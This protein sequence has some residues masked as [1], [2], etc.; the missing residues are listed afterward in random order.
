[1]K[2]LY[3]SLFIIALHFTMFFVISC[4]SKATEEPVEETKEEVNSTT[5]ELTAAQYATAGIELGK[6]EEKQI[7]G[8]IRASGLLDVPP[9]QLI[10]I[11]VPLGGTLK[12]T[13]LLQGVHVRKGQ[14]IATIENIDFVQMQQD[15]LE[16]KNQFEFSK[17]DYERQQELNK[18]NVNA[19]KTL[20]QSKSNYAS[21]QAKTNGLRTKLKMLNIDMK[22]LDEGTIT[23]V[24]NVYSPIDGYVTEV[25]V[26]IG[27]YVNPSDVLFELVN[28]EHLHAELIVFEKDIPKIKL[29]QKV[30]FT[31]AN[32]T[33]E[34]ISTVYLIGRKISAERT[35]RVHCHIED[36]DT[37]LL[38][39]MYLKAL[40]ETG[41]V[42]VTA[43]PDEAIMDYQGKKYIF[44]VDEKG[45]GKEQVYEF[46][47]L[48]I[49]TG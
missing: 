15:Y 40:I 45:K 36:S 35:I 12:S 8:T 39:G 9:Q 41:G 32:E 13:E 26:N 18:E 6:V 30:R 42:S 43:L 33:K 44:I 14:V 47:M 5:V 29:G 38:P 46:T 24:V 10:T 49:K 16:A 1:M 34:R 20:Q 27:K 7:S 22:A 28:T 3:K 48:E 37:Q 25:Y 4:G 21:W 2:I 11:S 31:L 19:Q 17:A 23:N